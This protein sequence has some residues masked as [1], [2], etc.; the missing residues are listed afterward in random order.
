MRAQQYLWPNS[1]RKMANHLN[2]NFQRAIGIDFPEVKKRQ[3]KEEAV[4]RLNAFKIP[5]VLEE[6][7]NKACRLK[8]DDLFGY[9]VNTH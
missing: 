8:P 9:M 3:E 7:L 5:E 6:L 4:A 1:S 2:T